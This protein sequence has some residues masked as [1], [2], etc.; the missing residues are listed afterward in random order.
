MI[1]I[2]IH[3]MDLFHPETW[4]D[5]LTVV[6]PEEGA[7]IFFD[8]TT[9]GV[10]R[11]CGNHQ[12]H[13]QQH[14][15]YGLCL[16]VTVG[17]GPLTWRC[18]EQPGGF[19]SSENMGGCPIIYGSGWWLFQ[20]PNL[21]WMMTGVTPKL[22]ETPIGCLIMQVRVQLDPDYG[23]TVVFPWDAHYSIV[24]HAASGLRSPAVSVARFWSI[25]SWVVFQRQLSMGPNL[26]WICGNMQNSCTSSTHLVG[27]YRNKCEIL[28]ILL[29][30]MKHSK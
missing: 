10:R 26:S 18:C 1:H 28:R 3:S 25:A 23:G 20:N 7:W 12:L 29:M 2:N 9:P 11:H 4:N 27:H 5:G 16:R 24:P 15:E 22:K 17:R 14:R 30:T 19:F 8:I 6:F 13:L 21:K